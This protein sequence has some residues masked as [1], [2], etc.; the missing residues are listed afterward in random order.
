MMV[1][2]STKILEDDNCIRTLKQSSDEFPSDIFTQ[3][4]R[5]HGAILVHLFVLMY[6]FTFVAFICRNFFLPSVFCICEGTVTNLF[7]NNLIMVLSTKVQ[8]A[9]CR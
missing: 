2:D 4:Q 5:L 9:I 7:I 1:N 3:E 6:C 8:N